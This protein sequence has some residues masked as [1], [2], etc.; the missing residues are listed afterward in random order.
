MFNSDKEPV[1]RDMVRSKIDMITP[2]LEEVFN[3]FVI[4]G[5]PATTDG[6]DSSSAVPEIFINGHLGRLLALS[7]WATQQIQNELGNKLRSNGPGKS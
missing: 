2:H 5:S 4:I 7:S 6:E 1:A 3:D